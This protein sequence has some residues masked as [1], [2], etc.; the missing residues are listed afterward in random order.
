MAGRVHKLEFKENTNSYPQY[1][2]EVS[3]VC[4]FHGKLA[5]PELAV[6]Q[7][8]SHL[9]YNGVPCSTPIEKFRVGLPLT[10]DENKIVT[11]VLQ[12]EKR[13]MEEANKP[14]VAVVADED[15]KT[16]EEKKEDSGNGSQVGTTNGVRKFSAA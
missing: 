16:Q 1:R 3:C 12:Q 5:R 9:Q 7:G 10:D 6:S 11:E 2:N 15:S 13:D 14:H 4:G 8:V